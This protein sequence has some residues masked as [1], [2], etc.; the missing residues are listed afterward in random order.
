MNNLN[1]KLIN[2]F[3]SYKDF[4]QEGILFRDVLPVLTDPQLFDELIE[5]M[6]STKA[7]TNCEALVE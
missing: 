5:S 4:P 3:D 2:C 6:A 7:I 1:E